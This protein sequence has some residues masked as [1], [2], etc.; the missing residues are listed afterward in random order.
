MAWRPSGH[1]PDEVKALLSDR[2]QRVRLRPAVLHYVIPLGDTRYLA[3]LPRRRGGVWHVKTLIDGNTRA[4]LMAI[5]DDLEEADGVRVLNYAQALE[6]AKEIFGGDVELFFRRRGA[7]MLPHTLRVCPIGNRYTVGHA[8]RD[9]LAD[10]KATGSRKGYEHMLSDINAYIVGDLAAVPCDELDVARLREWFHSLSIRSDGASNFLRRTHNE[11]LAINDGEADRLIKR[12]ANSIL[13]VLKAALNMAWR[14]GKIAEDSAWRRLKPHRHTR[15]ARKRVL[16][17]DEI[18]ALLAAAPLDLRRL[19]L[20]ALFTGCRAGELRELRPSDFNYRA[21]TI[22]VHATKT[23]RSR[24]IVLSYEAISF[25]EQ[26]VHG[27]GD[28]HPIF[29][30]EGLKPWGYNLHT[31]PMRNASADAG[32]EMPVVFHDLRHTYA[33]RLIMAGVSPFVVADQLGHADCTQLIKTYGHVS[34]E[35]AIE[36]VRERTPLVATSAAEVKKAAEWHKSIQDHP[37]LKRRPISRKSVG[38]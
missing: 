30:R 19:I 1:S 7:E 32:F 3:Y 15:K 9:Y 16:N 13:T 2:A 21:G 8:L 35:F 31:R 33:S 10:K 22:F 36:Q 6:R 28:E 37:A 17:D 27:L 20:G 12:R 14:D 38:R 11:P 24:N 34:A 29:H 5:A 4:R 25:F 26:L 23:G 18:E